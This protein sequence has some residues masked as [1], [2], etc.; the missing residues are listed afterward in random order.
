MKNF[1]EIANVHPLLWQWTAL[2]AVGW[3]VHGLLTRKDARWRLMLWRSVLAFSLALPLAGLWPVEIVTIDV[4][5]S[6]ASLETAASA[7]PPA[8]NVVATAPSALAASTAQATEKPPQQS[9]APVSKRASWSWTRI[10]L[11]VW[12]LGCV[13]AAIRL[14]VM[15]AGLMRLR[16][17]TRPADEA[18]ARRAHEIQTDF[19]IKHIATISVSDE[20]QSPFLCGVF[21]PMILLPKS[22]IDTLSED[23]LCALLRHEIAH[24]RGRDLAWAWAWRWLQ[25]IGWFHPLVWKTAAAHS[26]ACEEEADRAASGRLEERENYSRLLSQMTLRILAL[27]RVE[28]QLTFNAAAQIVRRL[29]HLREHTAT[30]WKTRHTVAGLALASALFV[31]IVGCRIS[32]SDSQVSADGFKKLTVRVEDELGKP[33]EGAVVTATGYRVKGI[34]FPDAY[35][36][37]TNFAPLRR[38]ASSDS[39]GNAVIEYPVMAR[40]REKEYTGALFLQVDHPSFCWASVENNLGRHEKPVRMTRGATVAVNAFYG[41]NREPRLLI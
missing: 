36:W 30:V 9:A 17:Q 13:L 7:P 8:V 22:L 2:L 14:L 3:A 40:E 21:A 19:G 34:H 25:T 20:I 32:R 31:T 26:L 33:V 38:R 5:F 23:E 12:A 1:F 24:L 11:G 15:Q 4:P 16:K 6:N 27:P 39:N 37:S 18:I 41:P 35:G 29:R 28:T 10:A